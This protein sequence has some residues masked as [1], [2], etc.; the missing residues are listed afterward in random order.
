M[1]SLIVSSRNA[2]KGGV[3]AFGR[4]DFISLPNLVVANNTAADADHRQSSPSPAT[5]AGIVCR[6]QAALTAHIQEDTS[7]PEFV[8]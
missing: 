4:G 7:I 3:A 5:R 1:V 2:L 6:R 8:S